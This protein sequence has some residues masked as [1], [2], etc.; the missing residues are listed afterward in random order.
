ME[1][2]K[3]KL[4]L[5]RRECRASLQTNVNTYAGDGRHKHAQHC[6]WY[7][8]DGIDGDIYGAHGLLHC[9]FIGKLHTIRTCTCDTCNRAAGWCITTREPSRRLVFGVL[10]RNVSGSFDFN[11]FGGDF[12]KQHRG[13]TQNAKRLQKYVYMYVCTT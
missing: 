11:K 12:G 5:R 10:C 7:S 6:I 3:H 2:G 1:T 8:I 13:H 4:P 9:M